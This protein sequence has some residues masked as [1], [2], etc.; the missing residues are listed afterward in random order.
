MKKIFIILFT[1]IISI[2][3]ISQVSADTNTP[4][5]LSNISACF[6]YKNGSQYFF[7]PRS[8]Y[9]NATIFIYDNSNT[10]HTSI[11]YSFIAY[12]G[13]ILRIATSNTLFSTCDRDNSHGIGVPINYNDSS[14]ILNTSL[15]FNTSDRYIYVFQSYDNTT[16]ISNNSWGFDEPVQVDPTIPS[17]VIP[18]DDF[19]LFYNFSDISSFDIFTDFDF[20]NFTDYEKL[21]LVIY[22][23]IFYLIFIIACIFIILKVLNKLLSWIFH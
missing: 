22:F 5:Y 9:P 19:Y 1:F 11:T 13:E 2:I 10:D 16:D 14:S 23:N 4:T 8:D 20:T 6:I 17:V 7:I 3:S 12:S 21:S 18:T 15:T